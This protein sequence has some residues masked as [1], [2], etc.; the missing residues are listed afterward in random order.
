MRRLLRIAA[1]AALASLA[2]ACMD[3]GPA[4]EERFEVEGHG[5]LI[6]CEGNFN[7]GN[8][9]LSYY[10]TARSTVENSVF[11]RSNGI[12]LGDVAQ[13]AVVRNG[14]AYI[15]VNNSGIIFVVDTSTFRIV[16]T[17]E[18]LTS[19]RYIHF[20]DD[21]KAY[22][23]DLYDPR[24]TIFDPV[25]LEITGHIDTGHA[26]TEQMA[27]WGDLLYVCCW[28]YDDK[29]LVIDTRTDTVVDTITVGIQPAA[30]AADRNGKIWVLT[31]GGYE[32]SPYGYAAPALFR[33]DAA[34]R[35]V[36]REFTLA[37]GTSAS[38]LCTDADGS[39]LYFINNDIMRMP[40]DADTLP[41]EP[42]IESL[43]TI[44]YGLGVD[45]LTSELYVADAVDYMQSGVVRRYSARGELLD[46]FRTGVSPSAFG[47]R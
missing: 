44:Y 23:T 2:T 43:G 29:V 15:A 47:F 1:A 28:S 18:G 32:G 46:T 11:A 7:F 5:V 34:T 33:I 3:F 21:R 36:E 17:V 26:S 40:A 9:S 37:F 14:R 19:P 42:F 10:D 30:A 22:V 13:S 4:E 35:R 6:V 39:T 16:G 20:A 24:I 12:P 8:A 31:D 25:T 45:P 38:A 41:A 27:Q